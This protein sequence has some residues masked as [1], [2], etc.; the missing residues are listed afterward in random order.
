M[1]PAAAGIKS[2][3]SVSIM[4]ALSPAGINLQ[5][6]IA[7]RA[8]VLLGGVAAAWTA[9][10]Y[11]DVQLPLPLL[12]AV[13]MTLLAIDVLSWWRLRWRARVT[14]VELFAHL[15]I[16]VVAL[17]V[18][19]FYT[20]G[21]ANPFTPLYLL[22]L[23]LTA[24]A[25]PGLYTWSMAALT[26]ACYSMLF[27]HY[28]PLPGAHA[29]HRDEFALHVVGMWLGFIMSAGLIAYFAVKMAHTLRE[30]D[31][32]RAQ[33]REQQLKHERVLALGTLAAGAAH[34]LGTPLSTMAVLAQDLSPRTA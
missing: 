25:L 4:A 1:P 18:V 26:V 2:A 31:R 10:A 3:L 33:M 21:S 15:V 12:Y 6:L 14:D 7:L 5:R 29:G 17:T 32:L 27:F 23:T 9:R 19:F 28:V 20:G 11:L 8:I 16:D 34:E 30:R 24:A 22:P 13:L